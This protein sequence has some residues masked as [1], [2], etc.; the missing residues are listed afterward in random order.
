MWKCTRIWLQSEL[1]MTRQSRTTTSRRK[2]G[3]TYAWWNRTMR[4]PTPMT[5]WKPRPTQSTWNA[6]LDKWMC[7]VFA[8]SYSLIAHHIAW[9]KLS[10]LSHLIHAWSERHS[11]TLSS[12]FHPT[13]YFLYS[14]SISS[15]SCCPSTST[16]IS[17]NIVYS[18]NK[19]MGSTDE[20][21]SNTRSEL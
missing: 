16:K 11:S 18:A 6:A 2:L 17:S 19:E 12:P 9:L 21:Y 8:S 1:T 5:T 14:P 4:R 15:N 7:T 3:I 20:S 13:S 10:C